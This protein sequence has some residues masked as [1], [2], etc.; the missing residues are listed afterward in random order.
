MFEL[1]SRL[2]P[3]TDNEFSLL[4]PYTDNE[5]IALNGVCRSFKVS[6]RVEARNYSMSEYK[7]TLTRFLEKSAHSITELGKRRSNFKFQLPLVSQ[8]DGE[9]WYELTHVFR[10][11]I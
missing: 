1:T 2:Y 8:C 10:L 11:I 6:G 3:Y 5:F 7:K 9:C 4:C